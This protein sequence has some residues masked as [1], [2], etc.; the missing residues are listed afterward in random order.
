MTQRTASNSRARDAVLDVA[1]QEFMH[2]GYKTVTLDSLATKLGMKKASLY[3]HAPGGKEELFM[4][5]MERCMKRHKENLSKIVEKTLEV[6][7]IR[8]SL[9]EIGRWFLSQ[10]P[11]NTSRLIAAD[12]PMLESKNAAEIMSLIESCIA[13]PVTKVFKQAKSEGRLNG[14]LKLLMGV[15]F[16]LMESLH[17]AP[18]YTNTP[19]EKILQQIIDLF[20]YGAIKA[21]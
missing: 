8:E 16:N 9:V 19:P 15:Y 18:L 4:A 12:L 17:E 14:D 13:K 6:S 11:M 1:E 3:Y 7:G 5:V 10:P 20:M 2:H 21:E